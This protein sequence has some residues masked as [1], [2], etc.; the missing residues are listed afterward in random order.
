MTR[1]RNGRQ[2]SAA[3]AG[4]NN[5]AFRPDVRFMEMKNRRKATNRDTQ[6]GSILG[7]AWYSP[8][9]WQQMR[10]VAADAEQL[11]TTYQEWLVAAE[12]AFK[13][14]TASGI[15]PIKVPIEAQDLINWCLKRNVPIDAKA[16]AQY[17]VEVLRGSSAAQD[18]HHEQE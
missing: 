6:Q 8:T 3:L 2:G 17:V 14:M 10:E 4:A 1:R 9:Q 11:E 13:E 15:A 5:R 12:R 7:V 16:R 18:S